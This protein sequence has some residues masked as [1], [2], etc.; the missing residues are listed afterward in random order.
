MSGDTSSTDHIIAWK[1]R[2]SLNLDRVPKGV[3]PTGDDNTIH[4]IAE[5]ANG[6]PKSAGGFGHPV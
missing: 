5:D 1:V 6:H 3:S 4:D 2:H